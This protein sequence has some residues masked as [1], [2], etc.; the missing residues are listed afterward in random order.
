MS[1]ISLY[2]LVGVHEWCTSEDA[3][4]FF[5]ARQREA[6]AYYFPKWTCH[7]RGGTATDSENQILILGAERSLSMQY[8]EMGSWRKFF[9]DGKMELRGNSKLS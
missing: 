9:E 4:R 1:Q 7:T 8:H 5:K 6:R 3:F 2:F